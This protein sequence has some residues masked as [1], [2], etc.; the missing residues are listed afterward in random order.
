MNS[1]QHRLKGLKQYGLKPV[2]LKNGFSLSMAVTLSS[3]SR[4][5]MVCY[6]FTLGQWIKITVIVLIKQVADWIQQAFHFTLV[7]LHGLTVFCPGRHL[8]HF[9]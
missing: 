9:L 1:S 3:N 4:G 7:F 6:G 8:P 5:L 2:C